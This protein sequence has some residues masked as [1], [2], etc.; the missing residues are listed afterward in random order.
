MTNQTFSNWLN[1]L[2]IAWETKNPNAAT[3]LCA[4]KFLWHE[5]PFSKPLETK[6]QLL[7]EWKSVLNQENISVS[8]EI[9]SIYENFGIA[10]WTAKFTRIP[11]EGKANLDGIFKVKLNE[12]GLCTEFRQWWNSTK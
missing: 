8:Y 1:K 9:L 2:K 12:S 7:E 5:T 11:S 10:H 6:E 3:D 4:E